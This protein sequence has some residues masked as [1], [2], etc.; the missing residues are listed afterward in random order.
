MS[1]APDSFYAQ[2]RLKNGAIPFL[3]ENQETPPEHL[4]QS[5]WQHQRLLRNQLVTLD[6]QPVRILHP[7][8]LNRAGGP[9]FSAAVIRI[10]DAPPCSGDV[11]VDIHANGWRAHSHDRNPNFRNVI[12][13]VIWD[14][15]KPA[16]NSPATVAI[17]KKLDSPIG[18]LSLWLNSESPENFP[19]RLRGKCCSPL[20]ELSAEKLS[21]LLLDAAQIRFR[22]KAAQFQARA[23][24][25]GWEQSLW[26]GLFRA[27]GYKNNSWPMQSLAEQRERWMSP[28]LSAFDLQA[29]LFGVSGLLPSELTRAQLSADGYLRRL[30]DRWWREREEFSECL[31]PRSVWRFSGQRP[32]NHPQRRLALA[33]HWLTKDRLVNAL[34]RWCAA[35]LDDEFLSSSLLEILQVKNDEFWFWHW[36]MK[37][38]RLKKAQP[39]IG[40]AR[41]TDLAVNVILPWL[42]I[43]CVEGKNE[44]LQNRVEHRFNV[45]P[46]AEDNSV[47]RLAR[48]RLLGNSSPRSLKTAAAQQGL[49]QIVRDFCDHSNSI[50]ENCGFP[51]LAR[52]W[53]SVETAK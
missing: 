46:A 19:E 16:P 36:T 21:A 7:G 31:L 5:I 32:A 51:G 22:A 38:A 26:E 44:K 35:S 1:L 30:W 42:W 25:V 6:G 45:W 53:N 9:D 50:C 33:A 43:R 37:S 28:R 12:L 18:Q 49:I 11:E 4:L 17:S 27:L 39:L 34:E 47:L 2:W 13:H 23:R 20:R 48:E 10:G 3:R 15:E 24:L 29:R 8:F 40:A 14:G 52:S 41:V